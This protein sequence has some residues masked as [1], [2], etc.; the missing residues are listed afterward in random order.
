[1]MQ[2]GQIH[3]DGLNGEFEG[4]AVSEGSVL[5]FCA[6]VIDG[7]DGVVEE[8]SDTATIL[9]SQAEES[10]DAHIGGTF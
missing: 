5:D 7:V 3:A 4:A 1:M 9:D 8:F 6:V 10:E 2:K